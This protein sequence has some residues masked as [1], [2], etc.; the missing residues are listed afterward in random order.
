MR[1]TGSGPNIVAAA[2]HNYYK[3][4]K[5][6]R[7]KKVVQLFPHHFANWATKSPKFATPRMFT[8]CTKMKVR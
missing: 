2:I 1:L 4:G 6:G 8:F 7:T 5:D 3:K